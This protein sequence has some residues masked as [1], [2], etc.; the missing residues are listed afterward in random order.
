MSLVSLYFGMLFTN[1]GY[2]IIDI[3]DTFAENAY[4]SMWVKL[5]T[6]WITIAL[7]TVSVSLYACDKNRVM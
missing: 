1:W 7:F 3:D 6:Q 2:A 5:V 4:F